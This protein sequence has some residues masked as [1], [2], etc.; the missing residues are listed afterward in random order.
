MSRESAKRELSLLQKRQR[1]VGGAFQGVAVARAN[2]QSSVVR[3]GLAL[4]LSVGGK[5][6]GRLENAL[7]VLQVTVQRVTGVALFSHKRSGSLLRV[8]ENTQE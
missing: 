7:W 5:N 6:M 2:P 4:F 8:R 3:K 1:G